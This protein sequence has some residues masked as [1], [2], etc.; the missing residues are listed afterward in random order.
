M[1]DEGKEALENLGM[2]DM[3]MKEIDKLKRKNNKGDLELDE[4]NFHVHT[5]DF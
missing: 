1:S 4:S 5:V 2:K 3:Y